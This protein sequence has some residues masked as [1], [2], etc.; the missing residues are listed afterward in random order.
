MNWD[1]VL[2]VIAK[3]L[4][5]V[6]PLVTPEL[7]KMLEEFIIKFH[8]KSLETDNPWDDMLSGFLM[9]LFAINE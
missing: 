4:G 5:L 7:R 9:K 3:F 8:E 2:S 1:K 6:L